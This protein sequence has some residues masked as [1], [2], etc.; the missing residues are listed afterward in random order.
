LALA[1]PKQ[2]VIDTS[3]FSVPKTSFKNINCSRI[4]NLWRQFNLEAFQSRALSLSLSLSEIT[5][6]KKKTD[7]QVATNSR[8]NTIHMAYG[9]R[10][11]HKRNT[12]N[13]VRSFSTCIMTVGYS[14]IKTWFGTKC[15]HIRW[16]V[17][18]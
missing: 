2:C 10:L 13:T 17:G 7:N 3:R 12:S 18:C 11:T 4:P 5:Q 1:E 15:S 9:T 14:Q 6:N 16:S 8:L